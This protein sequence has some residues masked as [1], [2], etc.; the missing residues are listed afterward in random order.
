MTEQSNTPE[1]RF[2][3][4]EDK[5]ESTKIKNI[6]KVV[7]GS[8]PLRS[9]TEY[10][11]NGNIPWVKTTDLNNRLLSKTSENITEL[12]LNSNN[13]KLLPK[14]TLLIAM[15]GGFNQIGRTAILN[16]EATTN[17]AISALI[18]NNNVNTKFLQSYLNFNVNKWKR[19]AA[20]SRKDPNI[21]KKDIENFIVPFTNIIEQNK[22]GD[23][24]SKLD[25]QIELEEEK[26]GLLQQYKKKY[27]N[28]LLSQEIRFK[29]NNG[30]N[31]PNWNEEKLG[32]LIDEV[33]EKTILNNQYPLLSST[34]NGLLTQEEYFKKQIGS[35]ENKGYKILRLNQLVLSP[36][37][38]WLGNINLNQRFDIGIVSPSYRIYNLN[39][40][41]NINFAK[42]VLKSPR[43]IYA[44]AQ[45]SE[46]GASVVRRNLNLDLFYSIKVSLPCIE[47]QNKISA[48]L[49]GFENL[50]EKQYSKVDL[51][52]HRK[53]GFLQKMFI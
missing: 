29:N 39:Q 26:L 50:I 20:S 15:Y 46:Q 31:Y 52:N 21:T 32:N 14:Q 42:T 53:Q 45:A 28:K 37:N 43:Y 18:S 30:Y 13:L 40:R 9:K 44:Y 17:Q 34:K 35:K 38:L 7:S 48:F 27:T 3:E 22:I 10:Y 16:M 1:L 24:F 4:F 36:Q 11:N 51:L 49:D 19:Y 6:F 33:N 23:F 8:T 47:E 41:F 12:A 25:R 2:P 5:W